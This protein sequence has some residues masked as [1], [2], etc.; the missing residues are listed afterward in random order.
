MAK[1]KAVAT[2]TKTITIDDVRVACQ[3]MGDQLKN[4]FDST[5]DVKVASAAVSAY[6]TAISAVKTQLI[7][8]KLT[9]TPVSMTCL[10][11]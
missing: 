11:N 10:D 6:A 3:D 8:K 1:T 4:N 2:V 5:G 9:G 7:F